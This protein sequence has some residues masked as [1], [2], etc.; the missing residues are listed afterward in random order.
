M[1][2]LE[3]VFARQEEASLSTALCLSVSLSVSPLFVRLSVTLSS[4]LYL[5]NSKVGGQGHKVNKCTRVV[6]G[7]TR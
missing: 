7:Q 1:I 2:C 4:E 3:N 5:F 6:N